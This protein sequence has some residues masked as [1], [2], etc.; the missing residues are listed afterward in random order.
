MRKRIGLAALILAAAL[1]AGCAQETAVVPELMEPVGV[2]SDVATAYVGEIYDIAHFDAS[3]VAYVEELFFEVDG[4][5]ETINIYPGKL[6]EEGEVLIE[7]NQ[8][9]IVERAEQLRREI[10]YAEQD[11]A[12]SDALTGLD[13]EMLNVELR[14]MQAQGADETQIA[15]KKNEIAQKQAALEQTRALREPELAVKKEE[16]KELEAS[17]DKNVLRAPFSG[18]IIYGK[19]IVQGSWVTAYDPLFYIA[20]DSRITVRSEYVSE[21]MLNAASRLYAK[22]GGGEYEIKNRP[23]DQKEYI[24]TVLA[25]ETVMT[26]YDFTA[27]AEELEGV[28]AGQYAAVCVVSRYIPDALLIPGGAILRDAAGQYVYVDENGARVKRA[29]EVGM[30]TDGMSQITAGLKEGEVVYVKD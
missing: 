5:V 12:Y 21:G 29:V 26:E 4:S 3:V 13:I 7:L 11:N 15:L 8:K 1:L 6:V 14:Q 9:S 23:I 2:Q 24:A 18:R 22:I 10:E 28:E 17:L 25:G 27:G 16:L 30:T 20:D 19:Q